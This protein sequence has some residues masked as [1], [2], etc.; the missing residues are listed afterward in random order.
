V[1]ACGS[2]KTVFE[3]GGISD[4]YALGPLVVLAAKR[5]VLGVDVAAAKFAAAGPIDDPV[6]EQQILGWVEWRLNSA[7]TRPEIGMQFFRDQISAN[8]VIQRGLHTLWRKRP[9]LIPVS[10][11]DLTTEVRPQLDVINRHMILLLMLVQ[12]VPPVRCGLPEQLDLFEV[13]DAT[14]RANPS[15]GEFG[16]LRQEAADIALRSLY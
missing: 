5:L 1:V 8:K 6:R 16:S 11:R 14:L 4:T 2:A 3:A 12:T 9:G 15:L 10:W 7:E 13:F